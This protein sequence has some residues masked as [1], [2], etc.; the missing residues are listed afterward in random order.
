MEDLRE[1]PVP[2]T[3]Q[4]GPLRAR[5][6][7]LAEEALGIRAGEGRQTALLYAFLFGASAIFVLGR[8]VRDTLF[9]SRYPVSALPWMFVLFG[10]VSALVAI[11]Y[12]AVADRIPRRGQIWATLAVG[13][14]TYVSVWVFVRRGAE[15]VYPVFY[16]WTDVVANLLVMQFWTLAN[17][18]HDPRAAK[19]L[20]GTI[21]SARILGVIVCGLAAGAA[22][23]AV[24]TAQLILVL[25]VLMAAIGVIVG[26]LR[27][28]AR[29]P[30]RM[31]TAPPHRAAAPSALA[32]P[33]VRSLAGVILLVFVALTIGDYQFKIAARA[34]FREDDLA[35]FFSL[36]YAGAGAAGFLFQIVLT[37]RI[38]RR[39]GVLAGM[40]V[41]PF[42]VLASSAA[43]FLFGGLSFASVLKFAD[44]GFQFTIHDTCLQVLYVPFPEAMKARARAFLDTAVKPLSYGLGG[45]ALVLLAE[46]VSARGL[47]LL[48]LPVALLWLA[49]LPGIRK[50]YV[51]ALEASLSGRAGAFPVDQDYIQ[52]SEGR[53]LL[54]R[55]L[56]AADSSLVLHA[57]ERLKDDGD[58]GV[59]AALVRL[60][61][62]PDSKVRREAVRRMGE[63]GHPEYREAVH[64]A[65]DDPENKVRAAALEA[66]CAI[67]GDDSV[68]EAE[69]QLRHPDGSVRAAA[70]V[71]LILHGGIEGAVVGGARLEALLAN[72]DPRRRI[73]AAEILYHLGRPGY[74]PL[75]RLLQDGEARVRRAALKA[76]SSVAD[77]RLMPLLLEALGV[78]GSRKRA[79]RALA[80]VGPPAYAP[81]LSLLRDPSQPREIKLLV[82]RILKQIPSREHFDSLLEP[83]EP[84]DGQVRLRLYSCAG[85]LR[86]VLGMPPRPAAEILVRVGREI[87]EAKALAAAWESARPRFDT[88]L[89]RDS[90]GLSMRRAMHRVFRLLELRFPRHELDM[91][92]RALRSKGRTATALEILDTLLDPVLKGPVLPFVEA[93]C[94]VGMVPG[95]LGG[96]P[97]CDPAEFILKRCTHANP[98][99]AFVILVAAAESGETRV[100]DAARQALL[101]PEA[102]A[103]EGGLR[104]L[105]ALAPE[106][107]AAQCAQGLTSDPDPLVA[108]LATR[109]ASGGEIPM[110]STVEKVLFLMSVP[111]FSG[112]P[113]EDLAPLARVAEVE[114]VPEGTVVF[115]EGEEGEALY[116]V[117]RGQVAIRKKGLQLALL[118]PRECFGEMSILDAVPRSAD[119]VATA[120]TE[121]LRISSEAFYDIL[122]EQPEIAEGVIRTLTRRLRDSEEKR[123]GE[124]GSA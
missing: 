103:R 56:E 108:Q 88:P 32:N 110:Y 23:R 49:L 101:R 118:G 3:R 115:R 117:M 120:Q 13:A 82:P 95:S 57:L 22:V 111:I 35:R 54:L 74:R 89:L 38:L 109:I 30:V 36:F 1:E 2:E 116:V 48:T 73:E 104:A 46:K 63:A 98:Y 87:A 121:V 69:G 24:G 47:S 78:E 96:A 41:M 40:L 16:V 97:P 33:Y 102:L 90:V 53:K 39:L 17:D 60:A 58:V 62:H 105:A 70:I 99:T 61:G 7:R 6:A 8:T 5:A 79:V 123:V 67:E 14:A 119:A 81:L 25:V 72:P 31:G 34:A 9:L 114:S 112:L 106:G 76:A 107:V 18:L 84:E 83:P 93:V 44:N 43:F 4:W 26:L 42:S 19:R 37:P 65:L 28:G 91:V 77:P 71:G 68:E 20:F 75:K 113:G 59:R 29:G 86:Q 100:L 80:A 21:G 52:D 15:W 51:Q 94:V 92:W 124:Q 50:K 85:H 11:F 45:L 122:H 66:Y 55:S 64:T 12:G 27:P 10:V